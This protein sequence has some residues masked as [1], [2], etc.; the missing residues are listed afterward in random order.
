MDKALEEKRLSSDRA[1]IL[2]QINALSAEL[3]VKSGGM[4]D[5]R[6][7][8][9]AETH[10]IR[11][12][13][14]VALLSSLLSEVQYHERQYAD[15]SLRLANLKRMLDSPYFGRI[16]FIE[17]QYPDTERIYIGSQSLFDDAN[18]S[19]LVYD[20]RAPISSMYYDFGVGRASFTAPDGE[21]CGEIT[22]KRQY[23]I[24]KGELVYLFDSDLKIDD[25][26]L[27]LELSRASDAK[28]KTIINSIQREQN[29]AIRCEAGLALVFGP[30]G[31]GKTSVGLHRLAYLLYKHRGSL[32]SARVRIFSSNNI[33]SSYIAGIIPELGEEDVITLDFVSLLRTYGSEERAFHG[34][35]EQ[36]DFLTQTASN[37]N[38]VLRR[39]CIEMKYDPAFAAYIGEYVRQYSPSIAEDANFYRDTVCEKQ[40]IADLY[41]DRTA[42]GNLSTKT[43]RVLDYVNRCYEEYFRANT[44]TV[45]EFFNSLYDEN[46]HD[47]DIRR[48]FDEQKNIVLE[49][50]RSRL[51]PGARKLYDKILRAYIREKQ[52]DPA[53]ARYTGASLKRER[54]YYEDALV[55][56]Y[57]DCLIGRVKKDRNIR[58]IL[59][60]EAQDL[61]HIQHR[62]LL[63]VFDSCHFTVLADENQA[64]YPEINLTDK[65]SL[66]RLYDRSPT[67]IEL[68]KSYRST[69][70]IG[71]FAANL[72]GRFNE[73]AYYRRMGGEPVVVEAVDAVAAVVEILPSLPPEFNTV[74]ILLS[75]K[76]NARQFYTRLSEA[77]APNGKN[78]PMCCLADAEDA[79]RPGVMV[80]AVPY[81]KGLEFDAVFV[82]EYGGA[83]FE[84]ERGRRIL[85]LMC[86]RAL[87]R[88]Y[89]INGGF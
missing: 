74:G 61:G 9:W 36:I 38:D 46:L 19:Y 67:V 77:A 45:T 26:I 49:D 28:I 50:L 43:A 23:H 42:A 31:S 68:T 73:D 40:R 16:D 88:L 84:G 32:T 22:F 81:A 83:V 13:D 2:T 60:D 30:A 64:L 51:F 85:Y 71:R 33:F 27:Q 34:P 44:K 21:V 53:L 72:I 11:D 6:K 65:D 66:L 75:D 12:F 39:R 86:T 8:M 87:H 89:L 17:D 78:W 80:M 69:Y 47:G 62:I 76:D 4:S 35:Y 37:A 29:R 1:L 10:V 52:L 18:Q 3:K 41:T 54:L 24:E 82:P 70:E 79:F 58:H 55:L 14:D 56:F 5:A 7:S 25:E 57:I 20:W 63:S 15:V 59:V 48:K